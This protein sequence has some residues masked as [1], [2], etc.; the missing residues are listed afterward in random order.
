MIAIVLRLLRRGISDLICLRLHQAGKCADLHAHQHGLQPSQ[1]GTQRSPPVQSIPSHFDS[2]KTS[3]VGCTDFCL[4]EATGKAEQP[5]MTRTESKN[6]REG[7]VQRAESV[8]P[9]TEPI[10]LSHD[11]SGG[12]CGSLAAAAHEVAAEVVRRKL[13][14]FFRVALPA[15]LVRSLEREVVCGFFADDI[16]SLAAAVAGVGVS[17]HRAGHGV[18]GGSVRCDF[19]SRIG[20]LSV[21]VALGRPARSFICGF[22]ERI[23]WLGMFPGLLRR[24]VVNDV[25]CSTLFECP[26][27]SFQLGSARRLAIFFQGCSALR[28]RPLPPITPRCSSDRCCSQLPVLALGNSGSQ[29]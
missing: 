24:T 2:K 17:A 14:Y 25:C 9:A 3:A 16:S 28:W 12:S 7:A 29:R 6:V 27:L 11:L 5:R 15:Q 26:A 8:A 23:P 19:A 13:P 20:R 18:H 22:G 4:V 1:R 21:F 10:P